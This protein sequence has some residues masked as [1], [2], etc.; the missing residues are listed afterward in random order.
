VRCCTRNPSDCGRPRRSRATIRSDTSRSAKYPPGCGPT[1]R[2]LRR[3]RCTAF[4][5]VWVGVTSG[6]RCGRMRLAHR[7]E[8]PS[9][10]PE[11]RRDVLRP[12]ARLATPPS[13]RGSC[14]AG[15]A[16]RRGHRCRRHSARPHW[17]AR[18]AR[19]RCRLRCTRSGYHAST[20]ASAWANPPHGF[21]PPA[22]A[23]GLGGAGRGGAGRGGAGLAAER[24]ATATTPAHSSP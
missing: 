23:R 10:A 7:T 20:R 16:G 4:G 11:P 15:W 14:L 21:I 1:G 8:A 12:R 3:P 6:G 17:R 5:S 13:D 22:D 18:R 9:T 24:K 19:P 2:Q